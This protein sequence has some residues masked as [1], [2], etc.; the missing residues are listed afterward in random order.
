MTSI[1][2]AT[3]ADRDAI[4][5]LLAAQFHE[6]AIATPLPALASAVEALLR[7]GERGRLLLATVGGAPVGVAALS[8]VWTLEHAD[9]SAWLE[10]LY[11]VPAHRERGIGSALL[12]A[13]MDLAAACGAVAVDLE[14]DAGHARAARLYERTGFRPLGRARFVRRLRPA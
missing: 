9:R 2:A 3:G 11:V 10:E 14:V 4:V 12:A 7:D 1:R 5:A 8:F 13:A 6:H